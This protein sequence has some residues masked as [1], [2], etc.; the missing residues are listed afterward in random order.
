MTIESF[1]PGVF[2][3]LKEIDTFFQE[4]SSTQSMIEMVL[5]GVSK[6]TAPTRGSFRAGGMGTGSPLANFG[7]AI[8]IGENFSSGLLLSLKNGL[9]ACI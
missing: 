7:G 3:R 4:I 8:L 5:N 6:V 2:F 1:F 9:D